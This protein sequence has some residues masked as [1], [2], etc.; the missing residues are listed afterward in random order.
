MAAIDQLRGGC[1][2]VYNS[3]VVACARARPTG[4]NLPK[5]AVVAAEAVLRDMADRGVARDHTSHSIMMDVYAKAGMYAPPRPR[6]CELRASKTAT[7]AASR[8]DPN[9][10]GAAVRQPT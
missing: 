3:L 4:Y 10:S 1:R 2:Y 9:C 6:C 5:A 8:A 7:A